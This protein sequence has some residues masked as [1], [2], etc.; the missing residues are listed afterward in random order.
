[1]S[2]KRK[3]RRGLKWCTLFVVLSLVLWLLPLGSLFAT[4]TPTPNKEGT[5][6]VKFEEDNDVEWEAEEGCTITGVEI[7][8]GWGTNTSGIIGNGN[9]GH[10]ARYELNRRGRPIG[11]P[12]IYDDPNGLYVPASTPIPTNEDPTKYTDWKYYGD[13]KVSGVGTRTARVYWELAPGSKESI[14]HQISWI[15]FYYTCEQV[16]QGTVTVTKY[17]NGEVASRGSFTIKISYGDV[18]REFTLD[19]SNQWSKTLTLPCDTEYVIWEDTGSLP[20]GVVFEKI[21]S[22]V[23][24]ATIDGNSIT[25]TASSGDNGAIGIMNKTETEC[26]GTVTVTKYINGEVASRGSF[27]IKISYGDVTREFTLDSS[28]QWSKTLTLPCDTEYVIWEDEGSLPSGVVFEKIRS[29]VLGATIDGNSITFTASSGDNGAIG[30]MN[31]TETAEELYKIVVEKSTDTAV[32]G[33]TTFS[34]TLNGGNAITIGAGAGSGGSNSWSGLSAGTY[35]VAE[36]DAN[37]AFDTWVS[38]DPDPQNDDSNKVGSVIVTLPDDADG[39]NTVYV[40]FHNDPKK[41]SGNG[42]TTTVVT[43][44]GV[45][46]EVVEVEAVE[47]EKEEKKAKATVEVL[48]IEELPYTGFNFIFSL[49]GILLIMAGGILAAAVFLPRKKGEIS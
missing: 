6:W 22:N 4:G 21:R 38:K 46:E 19:S 1:M 48:G 49:A 2:D 17:I 18:T 12:I 35:T 5:G 32:P 45:T 27:T 20:S 37:V 24:G 43:V 41:T 10:I 44:A 3:L 31:K 15:K 28:N 16:C 11:D 29:N 7:H 13:Y 26:Q 14:V 42:G 25:F 39:N 36:I 40:Y 23:L 8:A 33:G 30:I 34:F 47:E 9:Y